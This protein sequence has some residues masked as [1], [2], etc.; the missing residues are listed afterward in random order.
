MANER[1]QKIEEV[2]EKAVELSK[3]E[4]EKFLN[5]VCNGDDELRREVEMLIAADSAAEE[6]IEEPIVGNH[7]LSNF[8]SQSSFLAENIEDSVPPHFIGKRVGAYRLIR[9]LGRGG[10]GAV[11]LAQ[12]A[13]DEFK[14]WV[15]I[16]LI[17]RGMDTDFIL[18]RFRNERQILATLDHPNIARLLDGGT[19]E[20]NL[21][22]F[23]MEYIPGEPIHQYCDAHQLT[24]QERLQLFQKV[25]SAVH[26]AHQNLII[27]RDL[28]PGNIL[29]TKDNSP[30]LL[31]FGIAKILNP[32][33]VADTLSPTLTGMRLMTPEY[34]SPEQIRGE[35]LSPASD[36]YSLG[37]LLFEI[38]TGKRPYR[39]SSRS[40][41]E[42][43][44]IICEEEPGSPFTVLTDESFPSVS[45][46]T[47]SKSLEI[48]SRNRGTTPELLQRELCGSLQ[49]I[50][51]K[52][53]RKSPKNRY[54]TAQD[55]ARDIQAYLEGSP[56]SAPNL[57]EITGD[58]LE[59][60][61]PA[62]ET[63]AVLPFRTF[64][65]K[66]TNGDVNTGDFLSL[67]LADALIS[68]LSNLKTISVRPTSSVVKYAA[69]TVEP[70]IAGREL[71]VS[72]V[73]DG[74]IQH[75]GN[76]VRVT[77]QL[78]RLKTQETVWAGQFDEESDDILSLQDSISSQVAHALF[79][80]LTGEESEKIKKRGT[81]NPKAYESYL[82]GRFYWHTY[83]IEGMAKAL[84]CFYEAIAL[85]PDF[86]L[87]YTGVADYFNFLSVLGIMSPEESFPAAKEAA[88]KAIELDDTLAEAYTSLAI[89]IFGYDWDFEESERLFKKA[90]ELNP[91]YGETH[92]WYSHLL[93]LMGNH[94]QALK[95]MKQAEK[96][97]TVSP[98]LL[99]NYSLCLRNA[100]KY[101]DSLAK[102]RQALS[103]QP[104]Y[105]VAAQGYGWVVDF[106]EIN[107]EAERA[108]RIAVEKTG[109]LNLPLYA[110]GYVLAVL[111]K[112][113]EAREI[114][115]E[116]EE[117]RE[118]NYVP[119]IYLVLIYAALGENDQAFKWLETSFSEH[120]FWA[121][122]F[123]IDPRYDRLKSDPRYKYYVNRVRPQEDLAIHQSHIET[124]ILPSV[125]LK[126][127]A[128]QAK[129]KLVEPENEKTVAV[130][131]KKKYWL[132]AAVAAGIPLLLI[133]IFFVG[134]KYG[135]EYGYKFG[136]K[137][138]NPAYPN[139]L[140]SHLGD[141]SYASVSPDGRLVAFTSNRDGINEIYVMSSDGD[142]KPKRLT[143]NQVEDI[144]PS[145]SPKGDKIVFDRVT[146]PK[147]ESDIYIMNADGSDQRNITN[148]KGY[149]TQASFSPDGTRIAFASN[150]GN[151]KPNNYDIY[152]MNADGSNVTRL[153]NNEGYENCPSW[154]PDGSRI[155]YMGSSPEN[156]FEIFVMN[157][158]GSNQ[159]NITNNPAEDTSPN[160]SP[161]GKFISFSSSRN[162]ENRI[163]KN[164]FIANPDGS[165]VRQITGVR[166]TDDWSKWFPD[167][168]R[169]VF[170]SNRDGNNEIYVTDVFDNSEIKKI[171]EGQKIIAVFPFIPDEN[172][173]EEE[174]LSLGLA[175]VLTGK[176]GQFK[177]ISVS[178]AYTKSII[179]DKTPEET[180]EL[181]KQVNASHILR[182]NL[183]RNENTIE[184]FV[185]LV[186]TADGKVIWSERFFEPLK[187][188]PSLQTS[189]AERVL[190]ALTIELSATQLQQLNKRYT[191]NSEAYQ[192]YLVGRYQLSKR[193]PENLHS[194]IEYFTAAIE[195]DENF[196]LA[197]TG[198][199]D[200]YSLLNLYQVPPPKNAYQN[201]RENALK[202]IELD[203]SLAEGY[204]SLGFVEFYGGQNVN[205]SEA[206]YK[207]AI[208]L[209]ASY[210]NVHHWLALALTAAGKGEEAISEINRAKRLAPNSSTIASA[211]GI[212]HFYQNQYAEAEHEAQNALKIDERS[213]SAVGLL[214][215]IAILDGRFDDALV[216]QQKE[217][218]LN[219]GDETP[220]SLL[221]LAQIYAGKGEREKSL[222]ILNNALNHPEYRKK[223][224][225]YAFETALV[226][227]LLNENDETLDFLKKTTKT[228]R[229]NF[230]Y[231]DPRLE[232]VREDSRF[233]SLT[234]SKI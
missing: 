39:F 168:R 124:K 137:T 145:W 122:W 59:E 111:G 227:A 81:N 58:K 103:L 223:P 56:I 179:R 89:T 156:K 53:L 5:S 136:F 224:D 196:A 130:K 211:A 14:K 24:I 87:P 225:F 209:N 221:N 91:N 197:Y 77:A 40:P 206:L 108:C 19:T 86:A 214:R 146:A 25:C 222:E 193:S 195:K 116:L 212:V 71:K 123:P 3:N 7:T 216:Y 187:D 100:R 219:G 172:L 20:D 217:K 42:I 97:N 228:Y 41:H 188:L 98:S 30:K 132:Y 158:D 160:W 35:Q 88:Q 73:L 199:A 177:Q 202:A 65:W 129:E 84:V 83:E 96:L 2:F 183:H 102:I 67:G 198:R 113:A 22:Y 185:E 93:G 186:S 54:A 38:L 50:I 184:I 49:N 68:R 105:Y 118:N 44:R 15:A 162:F 90:I 99:V 27:H 29:V 9:E 119:P 55:F 74:R 36:I 114:V 92:I 57:A 161:D 109:G 48:L 4:R 120:D 17:K 131:T 125:Q 43:A 148:E 205:E 142:E 141:D 182:G 192:L 94:D 18:K 33:L 231:V 1:W 11:F 121:I 107:E 163:S 201:A 150:R 26:Y 204:A 45:K 126:R 191:E 167:S 12:R 106:L 75:I 16:K 64:R 104:N 47:P 176:L 8:L 215:W 46:E 144:A 208:Q 85:D 78:I 51:F 138:K 220:T 63:L 60:S 13:D 70:E 174:E 52:A 135:F 159:R 34:A 181:G 151:I 233:L 66:A 189:I 232:N 134:L 180:L 157:A 143:T 21:P 72:H 139:R 234:A 166:E 190:N 175:Q 169:L 207:K 61:A 112:S 37:V 147:V 155:V 153:T 101:E 165:N 194:A 173:V 79:A 203:N 127:K 10:M 128:K 80:Q 170:F 200:A 95:E 133:V 164:I 69:D 82:R 210:E 62:T 110:Y 218:A 213:I 23:V 140:T 117:R 31:D 226:Y 171:N 154:S 32:E 6:F 76:R 230:F 152:V 178:P 115:R 28:K 149:D 229:A